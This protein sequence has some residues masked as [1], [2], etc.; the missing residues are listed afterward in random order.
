MLCR[1]RL[2]ASLKFVNE[3]I[4]EYCPSF[5]IVEIPI[6]QKERFKSLLPKNLYPKLIESNEL[7]IK[8]GLL[9]KH[10]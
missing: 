1:L 6:G 4:G 2:P 5:R 9:H 3:E 8:E 7:L 10:V